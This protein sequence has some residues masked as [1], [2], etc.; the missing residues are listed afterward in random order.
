M[1]WSELPVLF[2]FWSFY[3]HALHGWFLSTL[4]C[5]YLILRRGPYQLIALSLCPPNFLSLSML[6]VNNLYNVCINSR[7]SIYSTKTVSKIFYFGHK[8]FFQFFLGRYIFDL[9]WLIT[10]KLLLKCL[11]HKD[12]LLKGN[13]KLV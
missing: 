6:Q 1:L 7:C 3:K 9:R 12:G 4:L 11:A 13:F 2:S 5:T 10:Q 8:Q